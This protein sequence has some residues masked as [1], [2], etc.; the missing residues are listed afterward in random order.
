MNDLL[1]PPAWASLPADDAR[2][3]RLPCQHLDRRWWFSDSPAELERAKSHCRRC[4]MQSAC[5]IGALARREPCGVWGGQ[6]FHNGVTIEEK[7]RRGRP[8][9]VPRQDA[10]HGRASLTE[11]QLVD[12]HLQHP[13][14]EA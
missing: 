6:I 8:R 4:P 7:R 2:S 12:I 10:T 13:A 11:R 3:V 9:K 14:R 1:G 5:L